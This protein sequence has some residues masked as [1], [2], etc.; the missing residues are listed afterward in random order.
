MIA[1]RAAIRFGHD[2]LRGSRGDSEGIGSLRTLPAEEMRKTVP[3]MSSGCEP[4]PAPAGF[5]RGLG[6]ADAQMSLLSAGWGVLIVAKLRR[7]VSSWLSVEDWRV[8]LL[9]GCVCPAGDTGR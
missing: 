3:G 9:E 8:F 4:K 5:S 7:W 1:T 6:G 2:Q